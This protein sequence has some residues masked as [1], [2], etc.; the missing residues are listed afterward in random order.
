METYKTKNGMSF[1]EHTP[2]KV[3]QI[4]S[5]AGREKRFRFW[6]GDANNGRSWNDENDVCGYVGRSSGTVKIPLLIANN[7]STGGMALLD[8]CVVKI[9]DISSRTTVYCHPLFN[10]ALFTNVGA[11]VVAD[12]KYFGQNS[13]EK[14]ASR[15]C[16]FMNGKRFNK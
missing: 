3:M 2:D 7:R 8:D 16:D 14:S 15:Y 11:E 9:I 10:Q 12:G 13:T 6:Y 5:T 4:L 1:S